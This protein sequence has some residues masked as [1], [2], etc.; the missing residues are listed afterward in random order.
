MQSKLAVLEK[1]INYKFYNIKILELALTHKSHAVEKGKKEYNERLEFLGDSILSAVM[2]DHLYHRYPLDNEGKLSRLKSQ[3]VSRVALYHWAKELNLGEFIY[4]SQGEEQSGGRARDSILGNAL[5]AIIGAI[6]LDRGY[7]KARKF[8]LS[9][10]SVKR[11]IIETDFKSRLQENVQKKYQVIPDY[12][13][14]KETG[15]DH[16]KTFS[17]DVWVK[18]KRFGSGDGRNKKEAEQ[19]AA[20][21]AM[22]YF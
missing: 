19:N 10:V 17:V 12:R 11:R 9:K 6:Y 18:K 22:K 15:P 5:E 7:E 8:I 1:T 20:K 3:L 13:I 21:Q 16:N 14:T 2:A 4:L